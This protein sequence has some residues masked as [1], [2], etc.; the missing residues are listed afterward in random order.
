MSAINSL[1]G[2]VPGQSAMGEVVA[3]QRTLP[4]QSRLARFF[5]ISPVAPP[6]RE[7]YRSALGEMLVGEA[8]D[9]LGPEWD[10]LHVIPVAAEDPEI[11]HLA[12]GPAGVFTVWTR[13][14]PGQEVSV[15]G[16]TLLVAGERLNDIVGARVEAARASELLSAAA[17]RPIAVEPILV[18]VD[19]K[20][21][22]I[23]EQPDGV[24]VVSSK[25]LLRLLT[26][27]DPSLDGALVALISDVADRAATWPPSPQ[28]APRP[29]P[30]TQQLHRDFVRLRAEVG[31][32]TRTRIL[33]VCSVFV[34]VAAVV[35]LS[36][37]AIVQHI[38]AR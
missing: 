15:R 7:V 26:R 30:D 11:D 6:H 14:F 38:V 27:L 33:W 22:V 21:L 18:I 5:G 31:A 19:S 16:E 36:V 24:V 9:N 3:K 17:G 25:Q 13:N 12:I 32:S 37:A 4:P 8:L 28:P 10:V 1:R 20:R 35:W 23:R 34:V 29:G 2:R